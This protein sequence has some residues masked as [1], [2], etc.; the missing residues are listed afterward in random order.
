[1][2]TAPHTVTDRKCANVINDYD[3]LIVTRT[4]TGCN[5]HINTYR[6]HMINTRIHRKDLA[7]LQSSSTGGIEKNFFSIS[8]LVVLL[9]FL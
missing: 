1:M 2:I 9:V 3:I 8:I 7:S 4:C 5:I 6:G